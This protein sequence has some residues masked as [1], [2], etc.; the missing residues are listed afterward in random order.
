[1]APTPPDLT[2][3]EVAAL[4]AAHG[5]P[6]R[7][8]GPHRSH[9]SSERHAG[10]ARPARRAAA[11][12]RHAEPPRPTHE[13]RRTR[14][15]SRSR[16]S[17]ELAA[18]IRDKRLSPVALV[19]TYLARID[20]LDG[21]LRAYI[22]VCREQAL[23][24]A[25][26]CEQAVARGDAPRSAPRRA[27]R[28]E[29]PDRRGRR[30][31]HRRLAPAARQRRRRSDA[32]VIARL[33]A[34]GAILLGKLNLTEFALGGTQQVPVRAAAQSVER[35]SRSRRL[36]VRLGRR[37]RRR[38]GRR[39]A[40]RGHRRIHPQPGVELRRR[41]PA[42][43]VG[44]RAARRLHPALLVDGCDRPDH[45]HRRGRRGGAVGHR[46]ARRGRSARCGQRRPR[47]C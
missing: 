19:N 39:D 43:D 14:T 3:A 16:R 20:R 11:G 36:V 25:E 34:A 15:T 33:R 22:T 47:T 28:R 23:A 13:R 30:P 35:R 45:A 44:S 2:T 1:M 9:A 46:R 26:R 21:T 29:G 10:R 37:G 42:S 38:A 24:E 40:R 5:L 27:L 32:P 41:R 12:G 6:P 17:T 4:A 31:H 8:R 18:R 7:R